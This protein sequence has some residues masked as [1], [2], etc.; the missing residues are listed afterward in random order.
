[1]FGSYVFL[2]GFD[3]TSQRTC[4]RFLPRTV[5][6]AYQRAAA[7]HRDRRLTPSLAR[8]HPLRNV[9]KQAVPIRMLSAFPR[10]AVAVAEKMQRLGLGGRLRDVAV[11]R[12]STGQRRRAALAIVVARRPELW[13]LD[14]PHAGLDAAGR[15]LLDEI[16]QEA[17]AGGATVLL[18]SHELDRAAAIS[19]RTVTM[20][21][22]QI[23]D[24]LLVPPE[25]IRVA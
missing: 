6:C 16:V 21:G 10:L 15:N 13:L 2:L 3:H 20:A 24:G 1:M 7:S 25:P 19:T 14:E 4:L 18:A 11:G 17:A 22:G 8:L 9:A 12:L 5:G 23:S